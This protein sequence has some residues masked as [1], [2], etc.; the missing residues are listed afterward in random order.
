MQKNVTAH[1]FLE[2]H[3][4]LFMQSY[5]RTFHSGS[6]TRD[7]VLRLIVAASSSRPSCILA[8]YSYNHSESSLMC[9]CC[10]LIMNRHHC[11]YVTLFTQHCLHTNGYLTILASHISFCDPRQEQLRQQPSLSRER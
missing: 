1:Q 3:S 6:E 7:P 8:G 4:P 9:E 11:A 10:C 5:L 2:L